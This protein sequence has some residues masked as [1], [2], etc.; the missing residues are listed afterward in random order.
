MTLALKLLLAPLLVVGTT[1]AGRRWGDRLAGILAVLPIVAGPI[2][3][4]VFLE[5]GARF[6]AEVA[7]ATTLGIAS[8]GAFTVVFAHGS[9]RFGWVA[10]LALSWLAVLVVDAG[11]AQFRVPAAVALLIT[12]ASLHTA[13]AVV[14][15]MGVPVRSAAVRPWWDLPARA[16]ATGLLV[17]VLTGLAAALG[18]T[19]TGVLAPCP[20]VLSVVCAFAR[21]QGG[22]AQVLA[23][24]R[25]I[26]PGLDGFA[27]FAFV[28]AVTVD[29]LPPLA[30][31]G[32]ATA[33]ALV[34]AAV[35]AAWRP[36]LS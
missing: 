28:V 1:L 24:F 16:V 29:R 11:L 26:V 7:T 33:A 9:R 18:P 27:L 8:L 5:H 31:F 22:H 35:L 30:S 2:L 4:V 21:A 34:V 36:R 19:L 13:G 32:L 3:L 15:R 6:T 14:R 20:I 25:G 23:L 12:L 10:T 17:L